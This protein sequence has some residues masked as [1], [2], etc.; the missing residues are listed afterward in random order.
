MKIIPF[1]PQELPEQSM[2]HPASK[3]MANMGAPTYWGVGCYEKGLGNEEA[4]SD[5][6]GRKSL[7]RNA[8]E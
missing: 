7:K 1:L 6:N 4:V 5:S 8:W 3:K 2:R